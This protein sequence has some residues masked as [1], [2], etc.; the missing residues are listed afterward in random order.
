MLLIKKIDKKNMK[1]SK[2][3]CHEEG[4]RDAEKSEEHE[5]TSD[6]TLLLFYHRCQTGLWEL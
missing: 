1:F 4:Q 5:L 3:T 2:F 6:M